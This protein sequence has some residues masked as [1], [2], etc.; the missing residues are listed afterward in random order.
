VT[1]RD[2][3]RFDFGDLRGAVSSALEGADLEREIRRLVDPGGA[4]RTVH[5]GRNYLYETPFPD[6]GAAIVKQFREAGWRRAWRRRLEGS[7]GARNWRAAQAVAGAGVLIPEP[8]FYAESTDR[9]GLSSYGCRLVA[10]NDLFELR[11]FLRALNGGCAAREYPGVDAP[12]LL[13]ALARQLATLHAERIWH[14]DWTSGNVLVRWRGGEAPD[15]YLLDLN[16]A[17]VGKPLSANERSRE[18]SRMPVHRESD[19]R[20]LLE[21]Y[22]GRPPGFGEWSRYRIYHG[23]FVAKHRAKGGARRTAGAPVRS[24]GLLR[25]RTA[26][27]HIP[28]PP[29]GARARERIVWDALSDQPHQHATLGEKLW[30]R[31]ADA[32]HHL[33]DGLTTARAWPAIHRRWR[34][35]GGLEPQRPPFAWPASGV[36]LRPWA[37]R[38]EEVLALVGELG[39]RRVLLRL[40]P[41]QDDHAAELELARELHRS[42]V[43]LAFTLPQNRALVRDPE[44]WRAALRRIG[45]EFTPFGQ[46]FQVGQAINRSKWGIW[47]TREY[48][49]LAVS[50]AQELRRF[51]GVELAGPAVIDFEPHVLIAALRRCRAASFDRLAA[52]LYVDRRG[53]PENAQLGYDT[54][55]KVRLL[56][57]IADCSEHS[58]REREVWLSE[59]NWPLREGPH[60]PAGK[61]V[62]VD[63]ERQADYLARYYLLAQ[64]TGW[65]DRI[66]WWQLVASGYGLVDPRGSELRRRPS[67]R[68]WATM[69][70]MLGGATFLG[71]L[72]SERGV[73][74][75][76]F[77]RADDCELIAGW[78]REGM[79]GAALE[80]PTS[81]W[82]ERDG[83]HAQAPASQTVQLSGSVR[84]FLLEGL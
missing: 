74:L 40:H 61:A 17:R 84:Y 68:A 64:G 59:V 56:R 30:V 35:L 8:L 83:Q 81:G 70:R 49:A 10:G 22:Y 21:S 29:A 62:S 24:G 31:L 25:K 26:H 23:A 54:P 77:R 51:P 60:S 19:Q 41:W 1:R 37:G 13:R 71:A 80:R 39:A 6:G 45:E 27:P 28:P 3:E 4:S 9:S 55:G 47:S 50:A 79:R 46:R 63:E 69:E 33:S 18:L 78:C 76:R 57:A 42:G 73:Y 15:L 36:A 5:W 65:V 58:M 82:I 52:L 44:R 67:F 48:A 7:K 53:A 11:Y 32:R 2:V 14:R 38:N 12:R 72:P 16:R 75:Y 43:E 34:E 66:D 20:L